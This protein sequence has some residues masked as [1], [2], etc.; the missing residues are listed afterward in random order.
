MAEPSLHLT[1]TTAVIFDREIVG[2]YDPAWF[3]QTRW[4]RDGAILH[5][6]TGRG[7]VLKLE[8]DGRTWVRR[9][10][11]R[12]GLVA[13]FVYDHYVWLGRERTRAFREWRLLHSLYRRGLPVPRP[14][15]ARV[16]RG[17]LLYRADLVTTYLERTR[18]LSD[19]LNE[20]GLGSADWRHVGQM[21]RSFHDHGVDHPDL[22]AHNIL[23]DDAHAAYL[24]DFDNAVL[25]EPGRWRERGI[26]RLQRSLRKV[27]LETGTRFDDA[28]WAELRAG[29]DEA[30]SG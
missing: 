12:G 6:K 5:S 16:V 4:K 14:I 25:R 30:S 13:N 26:A 9:H 8:R 29:Y 24:V 17:G 27:A 21:V 20:G 28:G 3:D 15:A 22:T 1:P 11:H 18:P 10:Y 19:Y 2:D 7:S 23:L